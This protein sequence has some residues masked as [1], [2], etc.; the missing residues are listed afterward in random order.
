M[1]R[2]SLRVTGDEKAELRQVLGRRPDIIASARQPDG[3]LAAAL[4]DVLAV[5]RE[6]GWQLVA[7]AD[8]Q[9]GGWDANR[10]ALYW[11]LV[12]AST[13]EVVLDAPGML[14]QTFSERVQAS[15]VVQR[16]VVLPDDLGTVHLAGRREPGSD[17][18]I[19]WQ[20]EGLGRCDLNDPRVNSLVRELMAEL[21][22]ELD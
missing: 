21:R 4:R 11:E 18:P 9:R 1:A 20:A 2:V 10:T 6:G 19:S 17:G 12:D 16:Q 3:R 8:I 14:P 13:G 22:A 7:W 15:I 5:R